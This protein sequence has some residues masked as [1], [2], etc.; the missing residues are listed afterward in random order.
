MKFT[1]STT[2]NPINMPA[3]IT[4]FILCTC[5]CSYCCLLLLLLSWELSFALPPLTVFW[6]KGTMS[7]FDVGGNDEDPYGAVNLSF[8]TIVSYFPLR[9]ILL[10]EFSFSFDTGM[11]RILRRSK[12]KI[13]GSSELS[14]KSFVLNRS[15]RFPR[16]RFC[17]IRAEE[18]A[19]SDSNPLVFI[20][21]KNL[22]LTLVWHVI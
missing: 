20:I 1:L 22:N 12:W 3:M 10:F 4:F 19:I 2:S 18:A 6:L 9:G 5:C 16:K 14:I 13:S 8:D 11:P 21:T 17:F 15:P 7:C